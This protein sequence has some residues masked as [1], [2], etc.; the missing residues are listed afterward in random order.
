MCWLLPIDRSPDLVLRVL[1]C[2]SLDEPYARLQRKHIVQGC[3]VVQHHPP[4]R[5]QA[6]LQKTRQV[7]AAAAG[8]EQPVTWGSSLGMGLPHQ[9]QHRPKT[10]NDTNVSIRQQPQNHQRALQGMWLLCTVVSSRL[11]RP[12]QHSP[13]W[14]TSR[15][16]SSRCRQVTPLTGKASGRTLVILMRLHADAHA[17]W[18]L[19]WGAATCKPAAQACAVVIFCAGQQSNEG[20]CAWWPTCQPKSTGNIR[21]MRVSCAVAMS[22]QCWSCRAARHRMP[23]SVRHK[24]GPSC[25]FVSPESCPGEGPH[26]PALVPASLLQSPQH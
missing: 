22:V 5:L 3:Q 20:H 6:H 15:P 13:T 26:T 14:A 18:A 10:N 12:M 7:H 8:C 21:A 24:A 1:H 17:H 23:P 4:Q 19:I 2:R 9:E 16:S 11:A 25:T